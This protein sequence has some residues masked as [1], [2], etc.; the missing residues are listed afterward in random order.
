MIWIPDK[1]ASWAAKI[2]SWFNISSV[3]KCAWKFMTHIWRILFW[4]LYYGFSNKKVTKNKNKNSGVA[5]ESETSMAATQLMGTDSTPSHKTKKARDCCQM[6]ILRI[7]KRKCSQI[8][9]LKLLSFAKFNCASDGIFL[10]LL[11]SK[12]NFLQ[13]KQASIWTKKSF[14]VEFLQFYE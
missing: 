3:N 9:I 1:I 7:L 11:W 6:S 4:F 13:E 10:K 2:V 14:H 12:L 5:F 8:K